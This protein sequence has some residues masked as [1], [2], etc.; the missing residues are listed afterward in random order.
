MQNIFFS[1]KNSNT[2]KL[3]NE[4]KQTSSFH[5]LVTSI[6]TFVTLPM[7]A[8]QLLKIQIISQSLTEKHEKK[9]R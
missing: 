8:I 6:E 5:N 4:V 7:I 2:K 9:L 3:D 1:K